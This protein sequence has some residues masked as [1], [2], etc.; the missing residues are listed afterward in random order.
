MSG[1]YGANDDG[2][3]FHSQTAAAPDCNGFT[4]SAGS[5]AALGV[6]AN[7]LF[8]DDAKSSGVGLRLTYEQKPSSFSAEYGPVLYYNTLTG[9]PQ[10]VAEQNLADVTYTVVNLRLMYDYAIPNVSAGVEVG[11][12]VGI[13]TGMNIR[14]HLS[15]DQSVSPNAT[16]SQGQ[17]DTTFYNQSPDAKNAVRFGLWLGAHYRF[18]VGWGFVSPFLGYDLGLTKTLATDSWSVSTFML[19]VDVLYGVH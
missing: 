15:I 6:A 14:Q 1:A 18:D 9:E 12:S 8:R 4:G 11:P 7:Y 3:T 13:V 5:G 10:Q 19:G 17:T 16:F 2:G